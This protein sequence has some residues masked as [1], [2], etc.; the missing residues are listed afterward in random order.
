[1][2]D[3]FG[4]PGMSGTAYYDEITIGDETWTEFDDTRGRG[5]IPGC[6]KKDKDDDD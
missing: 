1:V 2:D 5:G 3:T 4:A 6:K